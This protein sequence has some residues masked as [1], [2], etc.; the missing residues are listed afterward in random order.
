[1]AWTVT[2]LSDSSEQIVLKCLA[3]AAESRAADAIDV[4]SYTDGDDNDILHIEYVEWSCPALISGTASG[5]LTIDY[6]ASSP[7][8]V[9]ELSGSGSMGVNTPGVIAKPA[10]A[11]DDG[12]FNGDIALH[13][14]GACTLIICLRKVTGF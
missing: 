12:V 1:M 6:N 13:A 14:T 4:S 10:A 8:K 7:Q 11:T 5:L 9:L 2:T 3:S